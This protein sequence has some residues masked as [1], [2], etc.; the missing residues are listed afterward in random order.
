MEGC[1][2][3]AKVKLKKP[4]FQNQH[5][6]GKLE[7]CGDFEQNVDENF[8][9]VRHLGQRNVW[10]AVLRIRDPVTFCPLDPET[11][12]DKKNQDPGPG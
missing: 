5:G 11:G 9:L 10:I 2:S 4:F 12:M 1:P 6:E 7:E 3:V 8:H